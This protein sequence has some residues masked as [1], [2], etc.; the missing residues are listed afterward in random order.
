MD[1]LNVYHQLLEAARARGFSC[2]IYGQVGDYPL[3][4]FSGGNTAGKIKVYLS[5][6]IHGDEPAGVHALQKLL[7][8]GFFDQ[9]AHWLLCPLLNPTGL[10]KGTRENFQGLDLNRDYRAIASTEARAHRSWLAAQPPYEFALSLHEDWETSGFYL[11]EIN[12]SPHPCVGPSVLLKTQN[13]IPTETNTVLDDHQ[14]TSPGYILHQPEAD[15][16]ENWPEAIYHVKLHR[17]L[18]CTFETP[19]R[20]PLESRIQTHV[21]AV[22]AAVETF[23]QSAIKP[24]P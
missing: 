22:T 4:A 16:P 10:A 12:T 14:V 23:L 7:A 3:P 15:E 20:F 6:G 24:V 5:S 21:A 9:R 2:E 17:V 19:S 8:S 13:I 11:Y 18:S 1:V